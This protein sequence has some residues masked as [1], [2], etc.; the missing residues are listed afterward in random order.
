MRFFSVKNKCVL[1]SFLFFSS[2]TIASEVQY[3]KTVELI[4]LLTTKSGVDCCVDGEE[5]LVNYPVLKLNKIAA[6]T[7]LS[8]D[9]RNYYRSIESGVQEMHL[10]LSDSDWKIYKKNQG[11]NARIECILFPAFSGHHMTSVLC[12]VK[13]IKVLKSPVIK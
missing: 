6:V 3:R 7:S 9:D 4:G 2:I 10:V 12:E 5:L 8:Q 13:S 11:K 1:W